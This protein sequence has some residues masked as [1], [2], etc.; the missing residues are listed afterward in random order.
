M[1]CLLLLYFFPGK[2]DLLKIRKPRFNVNVIEFLVC[3]VVC[4]FCLF[5][6][7]DLVAVTGSYVKDREIDKTFR[8]F[9]E[10]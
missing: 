6:N 9:R 10:M 3:S 5:V 2:R 8:I 7:R 4:F 1:R